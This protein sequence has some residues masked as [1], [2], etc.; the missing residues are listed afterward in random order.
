MFDKSMW[1][2]RVIRP[3]EIGIGSK[4][5]PRKN[6]GPWLRTA[7]DKSGPTY[8]KVGQ[9]ISNRPDIFGKEIAT[10]LLPLRDNVTPFDFE[11]VKDK[12]PQG[13]TDVEPIPFASASIAQVH[14]AK[15]N[16]RQIVL[17]FKRPGIEEQIREDLALIKNG[18]S[19]LSMIPN[20]GVEFVQPWLDEF[21]RGLLN[22]VDFTN[23]VKNIGTFREI[24]RDRNDILIPRPYSK[25]SN[26][27][28]IVMEYTPSQQIKKPF[29]AERLINMF[30]E[31]LLYE[32]IIHGDL[33]SG[34]FGINT[35]DS[36]VLYDFGN[37]IRISDQYRT[38]MRDFVYAVQNEN[39][40]SIFENMNLMGMNIRD[41]KVT[42]IFIKQYLEYLKTLDFKSFNVSS[43]MKNTKVPVEL[44]STTL[45]IL[46]T[47]SLLEGL[48][49]DLDPNFSYQEIIGKNLEIL[50]LDLEYILYRIRKDGQFDTLR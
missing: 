44:D 23:E 10:S 6:L 2:P 25:L 42:K 8:I 1:S 17:K 29:K 50:F 11:L 39:V 41:E 26:N 7:L 31:Q 33:H 9:F 40:D 43:E 38:A 22:E 12:V 28:V 5:V 48:C 15:L 34:N 45:T 46:R 24:Y 35:N 49:K 18:T 19:L 27:D 47:Y 14:R 21:E 36:I 37:I 3:L 16:N 30:L 4:F 20:F 13:V 32:G